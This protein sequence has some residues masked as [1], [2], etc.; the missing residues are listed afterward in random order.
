VPALDSVVPQYVPQ[1]SGP[2]PVSVLVPFSDGRATPAWRSTQRGD[3]RA[4]IIKSGQRQPCDPVRHSPLDLLGAPQA[5]RMR[6][7][8]DTT[9]E[10]HRPGLLPLRT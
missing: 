7:Q 1:W 4:G 2:E 9:M 3:G 6:T 10:R 8:A 5:E